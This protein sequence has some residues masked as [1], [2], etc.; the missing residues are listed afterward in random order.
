MKV[1]AFGGKRFIG[2]AVCVRLLASGHD[3]SLF[4]RG[5]LDDMPAALRADQPAFRPPP[6]KP[7]RR[8]RWPCLD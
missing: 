4:N 2:K 1:L 3:V 7:P 5:N 6:R 8:D